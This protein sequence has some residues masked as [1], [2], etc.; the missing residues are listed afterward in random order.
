ML[1]DLSP[2]YLGN[3]FDCKEQETQY[4]SWEN[5]NLWQWGHKKPMNV[6]LDFFPTVEKGKFLSCDLLSQWSLEQTTVCYDCLENIVLNE[7]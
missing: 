2:I 3:Y 6:L 1:L 7:K 5:N 4:D